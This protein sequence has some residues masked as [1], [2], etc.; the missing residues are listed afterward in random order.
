MRVVFH[1]KK[2]LLLNRELS[3]IFHFPAKKAGRSRHDCW[4]LINVGKFRLDEDPARALGCLNFLV[5]LF[6]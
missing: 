5:Y 3:F 6:A 4:K 1:S 2:S